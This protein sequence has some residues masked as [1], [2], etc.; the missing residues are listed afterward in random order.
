MVSGV[1][2]F[3]LIT[4]NRVFEAIKKICSP[5]PEGSGMAFILARGGVVS[6]AVKLASA[7]IAK[8]SAS[9]S[10]LPHISKTLDNVF[11]PFYIQE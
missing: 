2:L 8:G 3:S 5:S 4:A 1:A 7:G 6:V 9:S 10:R 11:T